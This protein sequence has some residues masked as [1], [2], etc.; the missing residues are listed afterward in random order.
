MRTMVAIFVLGGVSLVACREAKV[1][2]QDIPIVRISQVEAALREPAVVLVDARKPEAYVAGHLPNAINI[3]L[4]DIRSGDPRLARA[5]RIIVYAGGVRDPLGI[6]AAK[7][8]VAMGY[9]NVQEY[10]GG[11]EEWQNT[12]RSLAG[13]LPPAQVRPDTAR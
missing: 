10:K 3:Y 4:P 7:R 9:V 8:L 12:G 5:K 13:S 6:A 1:S 11:V 2:D